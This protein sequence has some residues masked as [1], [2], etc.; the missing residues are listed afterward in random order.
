MEQL[1][2]KHWIQ[3]QKWN[4]DEHTR[5]LMTQVWDPEY[6]SKWMIPS[7]QYIRTQ[8]WIY[9]KAQWVDPPKPR[10]DPRRTMSR[11]LKQ[12]EF[13]NYLKLGREIARL[14]RENQKSIDK[15]WLLIECT[16][17]KILYDNV[18]FQL[19]I[20]W[21]LTNQLKEMEDHYT[22]LLAQEDPTQVIHTGKIIPSDQF[23]P[24][25][26]SHPRRIYVQ[27]TPVDPYQSYKCQ[28]EVTTIRL[29]MA[30]SRLRMKYMGYTRGGDA[31]IWWSGNTFE[32]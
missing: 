15:M 14:E 32:N 8:E 22:C 25:S 23:V 11:V 26:Q 13:R 1:K 4:H 31:M 17:Y 20:R 12:L 6:R 2:I 9:P 30:I 24:R 18:M 5:C 3:I 10:C 28:H 16:G 27:P 29:H 19:T 7:G 21:Q